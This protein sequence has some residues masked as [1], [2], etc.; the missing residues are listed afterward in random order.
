MREHRPEV[1]DVFRE[2]GSA[3]L[4]AYGPST[5]AGH[6]RVLR[7]ICQC[8]TASL[9]GHKEQCDTCGHEIISYNSCRN[10]HCPK[11]QASA[12]AEWLDARAAD[13]LE[14]PYFHMVFTLPEQLGHLALQNKRLIYGILFRAASQTLLTIARDPRRLGAHIG[15][16]MILHTWGQ[17]L[18]HHP[19]VHTLLPGGGLSA[20]GARWVSC[21]ERFFLPVRVLSARFRNTFLSLLSDAFQAGDISFHGRLTPLGQPERWAQL[22]SALREIDWVVYAKPPFGGPELVL[23][24]LARYTHRVAISNRRLVSIRD[25]SVTFH[26]KDYTHQ[27]RQRTMTLEAVEFIRRFLLHVLPKG[28][29]HIRQ[30]G[31]LANRVRSKNLALCRKLLG[32]GEPTQLSTDQ[33]PVQPHHEPHNNTTAPHCPAC[34]KGTMIHVE[35][36]TPQRTQTNEIPLYLAYD[37]L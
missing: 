33:A 22:I 7:D 9:G 27:G 36:I 10:R 4:N 14:A 11:C 5:T 29:V 23:K 30:Y 24:Y 8:R 16:L 1:A 17:T 35:M 6:K 3:Y 25:G 15:F 13:L 20:D 21:R 31:F 37:T 32:S 12:R 26:W 28:F 34:G 19:H 18:T 2:A